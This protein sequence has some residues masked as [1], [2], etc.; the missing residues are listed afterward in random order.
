MALNYTLN[1]TCSRDEN[2][3]AQSVKQCKKT[4]PIFGALPH[5]PLSLHAP[6]AK[7]KKWDKNRGQLALTFN[8]N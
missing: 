8:Y 6:Q 7:K 4:V 1:S 3:G 5:M 2:E